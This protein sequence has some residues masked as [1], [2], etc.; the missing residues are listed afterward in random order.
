MLIM[1]HPSLD[2]FEPLIRDLFDYAF[3]DALRGL[4]SAGGQPGDEWHTQAARIFKPA[5][6]PGFKRVQN[7]VGARVLDLEKRLFS[8]TCG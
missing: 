1:D 3:G 4:A 8:K 5:C 6:L 7:A 2:P